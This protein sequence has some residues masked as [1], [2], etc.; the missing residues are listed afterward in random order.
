MKIRFLF[1]GILAGC[2]SLPPTSAEQAPA[3]ASAGKGEITFRSCPSDPAKQALRSAELQ[4]IVAADQADRKIPVLEIDWNQILPRDEARAKRIAEVFAEGCLSSA[5]D[6]A[7]AALVF[8]HGVVPDHYY[9]A[10]LWAKKSVELG[11]EGQ[12]WLVAAAIDRY[13]VNIGH[14]QIY[15]AQYTSEGPNLC[16]CLTQT[17]RAF[18]D[19]LRVKQTGKTLKDRLAWVV[20]LNKDKPLCKQVAFCEKPLKSSPQGSFPG[21]W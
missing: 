7:A 8:Q 13:L 17:E 6:Y 10:Y 12:K 4:E 15:G 14:K 1:F 11:D 5:K 2:A 16:M 3:R 9:Q 21:V 19:R 18:P 20:E